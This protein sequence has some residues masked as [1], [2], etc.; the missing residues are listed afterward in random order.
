M[1]YGVQV[2]TVQLDIDRETYL[3][4]DFDRISAEFDA[5]Y[6]K[7]YGKGSGY[8]DAG[9]FVTGFIVKGYGQLPI[10][11]R[12]ATNGGA[13]DAAAALEGSRQAYF[14]RGF[15]DSAIY[16]YDAL[17][18]GNEIHGPAVIEAVETTIVVPP[19][20][21]ASVDRYLNVRIRTGSTNGGAPSV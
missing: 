15:H 10:P 9:R 8:A 1:R 13:K 21:I 19:N 3:A 14:G 7:L 2:H 11:E 17:Q 12:Q 6:D 20:R 4:A 16:R 5:G 18:A